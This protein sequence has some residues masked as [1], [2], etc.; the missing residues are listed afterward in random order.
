MLAPMGLLGLGVGV[1]V[2]VAVGVGVGL[3]R[4]VG[5]GVGGGRKFPVG[6][7]ATWACS[8]RLNP[9]LEKTV[10]LKP[11]YIRSKMNILI[12]S[13]MARHLRDLIIAADFIW[14]S[15]NKR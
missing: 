15:S 12:A 8:N 6:P 13:L 2:G 9:V 3:G 4:G 11:R 10:V 1:G 7:C 5:V 14:F